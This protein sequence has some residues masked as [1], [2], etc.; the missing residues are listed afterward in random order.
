MRPLQLLP[1]AG[2]HRQVEVKEG[3][4]DVSSS[5]GSKDPELADKAKAVKPVAVYW[6]LSTER[7]KRQH[8]VPLEAAR[9]RGGGLLLSGEHSLQLLTSLPLGSCW[10]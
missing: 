3:D 6:P 9:T 8:R 4:S 7:A 1:E 10:L 2:K 5:V